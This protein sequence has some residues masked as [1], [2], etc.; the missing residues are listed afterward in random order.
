MSVA[1]SCFV[2]AEDG[3]FVE[4]NGGRDVTLT[5]ILAEKLNFVH[6]S[7][8]PAAFGVRRSRGSS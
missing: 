5:D 3:S 7:V 2:P 8:D 1:R 4:D 6:E